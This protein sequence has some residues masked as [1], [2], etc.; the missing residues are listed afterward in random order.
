MTWRPH[1]LRERL[2]C[3][4]PCIRGQEGRHREATVD[5]SQSWRPREVSQTHSSACDNRPPLF[6]VASSGREGALQ[7]AERLAHSALTCYTN[8]GWLFAPPRIRS[9]DRH[10]V[11]QTNK[12]TFRYGLTAAIGN[13]KHISCAKRRYLAYAECVSH[14]PD[15]R[16]DPPSLRRYIAHR[17]SQ[18]SSQFLQIFSFSPSLPSQD[19]RDSP[20]TE[21]FFDLHL[22]RAACASSPQPHRCHPTHIFTTLHHVAQEEAPTATPTRPQLHPSSPRRDPCTH[23]PALGTQ[24]Q[25][26]LFHSERFATRA[27]PCEIL[28][29]NHVPAYSTC[30]RGC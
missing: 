23:P 25:S 19:A 22:L 7:F 5:I 16:L 21:H 28:E 13:G 30:N 4:L 10:T 14:N 15:T 20:F 1:G 8:I 26:R 6:S 18:G 11:K 12:Q 2:P 27:L 17:S 9:R 24:S 3:F 29:R